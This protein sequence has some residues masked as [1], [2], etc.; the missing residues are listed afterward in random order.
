MASLF[1]TP[2]VHHQN[3]PKSLVHLE[4]QRLT[5]VWQQ[6]AFTKLLGLQ[7]KICYRKGLE[8]RAADA[9]SRRRHP[10]DITL[11]TVTECQPIWLEEVRASYLTNEHTKKLIQRLQQAPDPK[12]RFSWHDN[13]LYFRKRI[14]LG[15]SAELQQKILSAFHSSKI[16]GHSGFP[17]TYARIR[18]LFAWPKMK[19]Q[20]KEFVQTCMICQQAKPER[21]K[22][23]GLLEPLSTPDAAWQM[24]TMD[25]VEGLPTSGNANCIMVVVDKFTLYAH[26]IPL[27][28]PFTATKV[29]TAYMNNVFK[30]H[31][32][33]QVMLSDRD[34]IFTSKFWK[35]LFEQL[36]S[37]LRMSSAYHPQTDGQSE[38]VNQ[39]LEIYLRCFTHACPK[40]WSHF[41][42]LAEFWYNTSYHSAIKMSPFVALY[43]HEPR[44]WG[45][46]ASHTCT[47]P[48]LEDWLEER[49]Q[50]QQLLQHNLNHARQYM[51]NQADKKRTERTFQLGEEVF[52]K[53]QP[54]IQNSVMR[55]TNAKLAFRYFGPFRISKCINAVA[56]QVDL[57]PESRI[58][59]VFHV[60]QLRKVLK[61]GI[62]ASTA[63]PVFTDAI[64]V[65]VRSSSVAGARLLQGDESKCEYNGLQ[66]VMKN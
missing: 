65:P 9:L 23:P 36:G 40:K 51:K 16:G 32:L 27:L 37:E 58:H 22:Y 43:G 33:P 30:L 45:V 41:I 56:Y 39:C 4:E 13:L 49:K 19:A 15:G 61:R 55:R 26:F 34:P 48:L 29:A 12:G 42:S 20:T 38:R 35:E 60:S 2:R 21:I 24:V 17:A 7:Y 5:T 44:H 53:L 28:H 10:E 52:I 8:N 18:R 31:S 62:Q 64:P 1:A 63:L 57:P 54:Y 59:P 3:G 46:E 14:W 11:N 25:F 66:T 6:K 47:A 50:M